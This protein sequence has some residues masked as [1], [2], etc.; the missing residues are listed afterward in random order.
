[1][2]AMKLAAGQPF[3]NM[4]VKKFGGGEIDLSAATE[5]HDWR[6]VVVYRGKH[7]PFCTEYLV[8]LR[9]MKNNLLLQCLR[10]QKSV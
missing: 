1:M 5:P 4:I 9:D 6:M 3:P 2:T 8:E 10:T 7:C